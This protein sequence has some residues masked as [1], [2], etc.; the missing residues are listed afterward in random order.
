MSMI[1]FY[2]PLEPY[3]KERP[4][5]SPRNFRFITPA[6]TRAFENN[7]RA[8]ANQYRPAEALSGPLTMQI[9]LYLPRPPSVKRAT[10][11]VKP[12]ID[13]F[14]KSVIDAMNTVFFKD[15]GQIVKLIVTKLYSE[16]PDSV[17]IR[18]VLSSFLWVAP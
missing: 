1:E 4:R 15:D 13:N 5:F 9:A 18:V 10:P 12:D 2:V 14:A 7:F 3:P 17:G 6:N 16:S 11:H 8:L